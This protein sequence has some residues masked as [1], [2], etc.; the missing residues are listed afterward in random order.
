MRIQA[1]LRDIMRVLNVAEKNDAAKSIAAHLSKGNSRMVRFSSL[2]F[3]FFSLFL[4]LL[5]KKFQINLIDCSERAFQSL[6]KSMNSNLTC[7]TN[8]A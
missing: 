8:V 5:S 7:S 6:T 2:F 1:S 3:L 4:F